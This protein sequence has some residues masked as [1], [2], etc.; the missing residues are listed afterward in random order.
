MNQSVLSDSGTQNIIEN[1]S[2]QM[3]KLLRLWLYHLYL[4]YST[5]G[6][7]HLW[8][9]HHWICSLT[10][11]IWR[12]SAAAYS[13]DLEIKWDRYNQSQRLNIKVWVFLFSGQWAL[14]E[15]SSVF[16]CQLRSILWVNQVNIAAN[17]GHVILHQHW[18]IGCRSSSDHSPCQCSAEWGFWTDGPQAAWLQRLQWQRRTILT[19]KDQKKKMGNFSNRKFATCSLWHSREGHSHYHDVHHTI[20]LQKLSST[21]LVEK[22]GWKSLVCKK[23]KMVVMMTVTSDDLSIMTQGCTK[24]VLW[25]CEAVEL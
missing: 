8:R 10:Q 7:A 14:S 15:L 22:F 17:R 20:I 23:W 2:D 1:L 4:W 9:T 19:Y 3:T 24:Y 6:F 25:D 5:N 12:C 16:V 11:L 18:S 13:L 21:E